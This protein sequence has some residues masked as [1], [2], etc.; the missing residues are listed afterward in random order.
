MI[1]IVLNGSNWFGLETKGFIN[2]SSNT[3]RIELWYSN[4][5]KVIYHLSKVKISNSKWNLM[6]ILYS[7]IWSYLKHASNSLFEMGF[8]ISHHAFFSR[9][10]IRHK[11]VNNFLKEHSCFGFVFTNF[12]KSYLYSVGCA[13]KDLDGSLRPLCKFIEYC[14]ICSSAATGCLIANIYISI[15][16]GG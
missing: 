11:R 10:F 2:V 6:Y 4:K 9:R 16:S 5:A 14:R 15:C 3:W 8:I 12:F 7:S 13:N 1:K